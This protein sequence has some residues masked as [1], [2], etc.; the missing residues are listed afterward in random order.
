MNTDDGCAIYTDV[1]DVTSYREAEMLKG[2]S[3]EIRP[4]D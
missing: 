3:R 1:Q 2:A 4:T